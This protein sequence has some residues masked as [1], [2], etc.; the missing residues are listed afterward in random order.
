MF[1]L[2]IIKNLEILNLNSLNFKFSDFKQF[3]AYLDRSFNAVNVKIVGQSALM[4][5]AV[6]DAG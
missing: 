1:S 6:K 3:L 2:F 4:S 5:L